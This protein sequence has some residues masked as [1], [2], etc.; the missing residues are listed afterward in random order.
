MALS[1]DL[2]IIRNYKAMGLSV[3]NQGVHS[4]YMFYQI[5]FDHKQISMLLK[6]MV[7]FLF[8]FEL[9]NL[10][11]DNEDRIELI[12]KFQRIFGLC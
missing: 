6:S 5:Q 8:I 4:L 11:H 3:S 1:L 7:N 12:R 9:N 2:I 10:F